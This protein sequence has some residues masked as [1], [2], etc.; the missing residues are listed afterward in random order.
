MKNGPMQLSEKDLWPMILKNLSS[1]KEIIDNFNKM[2]EDAVAHLGSGVGYIAKGY[3]EIRKMANIL[4][5]NV[6]SDLLSYYFL[7]RFD[8]GVPINIRLNFIS[9]T[10]T[11]ALLEEDYSKALALWE[12][13]KKEVETLQS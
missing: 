5:T 2:G 10:F 13:A 6:V 4:S 11:Q 7:H 12:L 1:C 8:N 9:L 3:T